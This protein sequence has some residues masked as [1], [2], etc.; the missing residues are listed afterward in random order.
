MSSEPELNAY[1]DGLGIAFLHLL[2][3]YVEFALLSGPYV[4]GY[5]ARGRNKFRSAFDLCI[6]S[7]MVGLNVDLDRGTV[8]TVRPL[9]TQTNGNTVQ[10]EDRKT[11]AESDGSVT[12]NGHARP[13][14]IGAWLPQSG[15]RS[16]RTR[17]QALARHAV[18]A[19]QGIWTIDTL[20]A[21]ERYTASTTLGNPHGT[22]RAVNRFISENSVLL[23]PGTTWQV[24]APQL[25]V[26]TVITLSVAATIWQG[27]VGGYHVF[28][29]MALLAGWEVESWEVDLM[30]Q[31]WKA[32]SLLDI[33]G[34]RWHQLFRVGRQHRR[35]GSSLRLT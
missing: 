10:N 4:D 1:N 35:D 21:L 2:I 26:E 29:L 24:P 11:E 3:K 5:T 30:D 8:G 18:L 34:R 32:D 27:L 7:R 12:I 19:L 17:K 6:N 14:Q 31:P 28:A 13:V 22:H 9:E 16:T 20:L 33:W 23:F 15:S 25:L